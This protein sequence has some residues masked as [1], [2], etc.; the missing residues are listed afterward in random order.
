MLR[1][2]TYVVLLSLLKTA[3]AQDQEYSDESAEERPRFGFAL[4]DSIRKIIIFASSLD[5]DANDDIGIHINGVINTDHA[6][7]GRTND[8]AIDSSPR[9][10]IININYDFSTDIIDISSTSSNSAGF[11]NIS[12][13]SS[14]SSNSDGF[15]NISSACVE[16]GNYFSATSSSSNGYVNSIDTIN[17]NDPNCKPRVVDCVGTAIQC[18]EESVF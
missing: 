12:S 5:D 14:I 8:V 4:F 2:V 7:I 16:F 11:I 3:W 17:V 18:N 13:I 6:T 9:I 1:L 15:I 10:S